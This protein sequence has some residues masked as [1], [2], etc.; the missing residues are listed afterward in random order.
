MNDKRSFL[1]KKY[2]F[3]IPILLLAGIL[4]SIVLSTYLKSGRLI[5]LSLIG[6]VI[7]TLVSSVFNLIYFIPLKLMVARFLIPGLL[8]FILLLFTTDSILTGLGMV[9]LLL[10]FLWNKKW[11]KLNNKFKD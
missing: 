8:T 2:L 9:N 10:G 6:T 1:I 11:E 5:V 4:L 7:V 3:N